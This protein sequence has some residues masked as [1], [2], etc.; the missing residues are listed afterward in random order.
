MSV[1]LRVCIIEKE[2]PFD[3]SHLCFS[4]PL[5]LLFRLL[6]EWLLLPLHNRTHFGVYPTLFASHKRIQSPSR[7]R[8]M[9]G[10]WEGQLGPLSLSVAEKMSVHLKCFLSTLS[11]S[12]MRTFCTETSALI[13]SIHFLSSRAS[14]RSSVDRGPFPSGT[15][16][17]H[18]IKLTLSRRLVIHYLMLASSFIFV[19]SICLSVCL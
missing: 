5:Y 15:F 2:K 17:S 9:R 10:E 3:K 18:S 8:H 7:T 4:V 16:E 1:L 11:T 13:Q 6:S 19:R 12:S 14:I